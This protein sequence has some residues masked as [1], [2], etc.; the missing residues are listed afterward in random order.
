MEKYQPGN[1]EQSWYQEWE[2]NNYFAPSG[3]GKPFC[4]MIPP[5]NVTGTL[6]MGHAFQHSL[7]DSLIRYHRMKGRNTLWQ[8]G[9]D[10]AGI[11]TQM[12]IEE[13][14]AAEGIRA[15]EIGREKFLQRAWQWKEE[16]GGII[17]Q[18]LRRMGASLNWPTERFTLDEGFSNAVLEVFIKLFDEGLIYRGKRLVNWDPQLETSLSDLEVLSEEEKGHMWHF[19]YPLADGP[20]DGF[21]YLVVA[22]TRPETM[23]GDTAV[24]VNPSDKRYQ[25]LVGSEVELPLTGRR[26]P[27]IADHHVDPEFGTG[28]VKITPAH[29]FNDYE[30][31]TRHDL[32]IINVFTESAHLND[33]VP[34][35]YQG[36]DRF[37]A[38][39]AVVED[40]VALDL[41]EKIED[42]TLAVPRGERSGV[43][44]EPFLSDQWF[45]KVESL[46]K[47][48]IEVVEKGEIEFIPRNYE[49]TYFAWMRDIQDWCISRQQ[50]WGHRI[51]AWY[52]D[53]GNIYVGKSEQIVREKYSLQAD[54]P[55]KQDEDVLDTWFS[56]QLWTFATLGWP[57]KTPELET[58]HS[59]NLM[60]TG[61]DIISLWVSRMIMS[62]LYFTGEIPFSQVYIHGLVT[63]ADGRKMSKS[64]GNG[65]D[66]LDIID[67]ISLDDLV[68]K[69]TSNLMQPRMAAQ[70]EKNTRKEYPNG[71]KTYGADA[72]RFTFCAIATRSRTVR[73]DMHRVEGYRNFC[74]KLWNA[75]NFV[76]MNT[77]GQDCGG[78]GVD[79]EL[80]LADRWINSILQQT[81]KDISTAMET[82]RFDLAA[83]AYYEFVWDE[84]CD[85]YL[86]FCKPVLYS[87]KSSDNQLRGTRHNLIDVLEKIL[88]LG[89]PFIP[90]ITEDI[91]Q[92][93]K[94]RI[95][96]SFDTI[97]LQPYPEVNTEQVNTQSEQDI[98]WIKEVVNG[99]RNIRGVMNISFG[100]KI[101][102]LF[103]NGS[104]NDR[105][106]LEANRH[107]LES[108]AKSESLTWLENEAQI[109]GSA[110][111][112][113]GE[114]Q[115]LVPMAGIIDK[116]AELIRLTKQIE[117]KQSDITGAEGKINNPKFVQNAPAEVV[118][119]ERARLEETRLALVQLEE[120]YQ[121]V[122][123]I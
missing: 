71:I 111:H 106:C 19:R 89:H 50:W 43:I 67:G 54:L 75:A 113:V 46:A 57:E 64:K 65:L 36:M 78:S 14:L 123:A 96:T 76:L 41:L 35:K 63:D 48:A 25:S 40:L 31:G 26:I 103:A 80:S 58:F 32:A 83:K 9:T 22:T 55:L 20:I 49:N 52:D 15:S 3:N 21:D 95:S 62:A 51:P 85:W 61:H 24:A 6:H 2:S 74:N 98:D 120:Q 99:T 12:L 121:R 60:V 44:V 1:I 87:D 4:I 7:V 5:P 68:K 88:R 33:R 66:P 16:S 13:Q 91:W 105:R 59:T 73:F 47:P 97:M 108:L 45:V 72:L 109:P 86:E 122:A 53:A 30:I 27:I 84:F 107:L 28:C 37:Q 39:Q 114:M 70:I 118:D 110:T 82:Y 8:M 38:R 56:S 104:E 92:R 18:Q 116:D 102:I 10:H 11:S 81:I 112:L 29:D 93:L 42:H 69:R 79:L 94:P 100:K 119:K 17:S 115:V 101:P 77:D 34:A 90:F 23:L 117:R